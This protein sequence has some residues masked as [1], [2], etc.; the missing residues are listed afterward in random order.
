MGKRGSRE[1]TYIHMGVHEDINDLMKWEERMSRP[2]SVDSQ[3]AGCCIS[4]IKIKVLCKKYLWKLRIKK[5][6]KDDGPTF[7]FSIQKN[8]RIQHP[9]RHHLY[10]ADQSQN[11][12]TK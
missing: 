12:T 7:I 8:K 3:V 2:T 9:H 6:K 10:I 4:T 11:S 5:W 1:Y